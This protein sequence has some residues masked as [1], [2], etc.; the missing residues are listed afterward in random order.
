MNQPTQ[1]RVRQRPNGKIQY[2]SKGN[3]PL[4]VKDV[5]SF[6]NIE[7][8][9]DEDISEEKREELLGKWRGS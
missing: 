3:V 8:M 2:L 5:K 4:T 7:L 1:I 6:D 9:F